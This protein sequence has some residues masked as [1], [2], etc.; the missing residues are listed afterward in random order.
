[1]FE[2]DSVTKEERRKNY[3][4]FV[5]PS[6][7][8]MFFLSGLLHMVK[9]EYDYPDGLLIALLFAILATFVLFL[10]GCAKMGYFLFGGAAGEDRSVVLQILSPIGALAGIGVALFIFLLVMLPNCGMVSEKSRRVSCKANMKQI[11]LALQAYAKDYGGCFPQGNAVEAFSTL[12]NG[13]YLSA[14]TRILMCPSA[15]RHRCPGNEE[16]SDKTVSYL[17]LG[18]GG[19]IGEMKGDSILVIERNG[20]HSVYGNVLFG[21]GEVKGLKGKDWEDAL[22]KVE[23]RFSGP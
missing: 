16:L 17:Y 20:N 13:C 19:S 5:F 4:L 22:S 8:A 21:D 6:G 7:L 15:H 23:P 10:Y 9:S 1:M 12:R 2:E 11:Y 18:A 3:L 14:D